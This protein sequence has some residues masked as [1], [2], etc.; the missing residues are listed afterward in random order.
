MHSHHRPLRAVARA[1]RCAALLATLGGT[2]FALT[3][4]TASCSTNVERPQLHVTRVDVVGLDLSGVTLRT[5]IAAYNPN[6]FE[7]PMRDLRATLT[8]EGV[9]A[10]ATMSNFQAVLPPRREIPVTVDVSVP[11]AAASDTVRVALQRPSIP[12]EITGTITAEHYITVTAPFT[13]RGVLQR[14]ELARTALPGGATGAV[15]TALDLIGQIVPLPLVHAPHTNTAADAGAA[16]PAPG[17][18]VA[19]AAVAPPAS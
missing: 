2:S 3:A 17:A 9:R 19:D 5:T 6:G 18:T 4:A 10:P 12:Y 15:S 1:A 14:D 13:H 8:L 7:L 11:W 16:A